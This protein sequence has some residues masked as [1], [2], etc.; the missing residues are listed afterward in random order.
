ML[1]DGYIIY[2]LQPVSVVCVSIASSALTRSIE[3]YFPQWAEL[4][5]LEIATLFLLP[6]CHKSLDITLQNQ[7]IFFT[8]VLDTLCFD[9]RILRIQSFSVGLYLVPDYA[10]CI[11]QMYLLFQ[12]S[13]HNLLHEGVG[14]V[15]VRIFW[16]LW[17]GH[18][19][20][21]WFFV[22]QG[23]KVEEET[24]D[25]LTSH[26][27]C[28]LCPLSHIY[29]NFFKM[30]LSCIIFEV[31]IENRLHRSQPHDDTAVTANYYKRKREDELVNRT[32]TKERKFMGKEYGPRTCLF[33][34]YML[35]TWSY[36]L[37]ICN[38]EVNKFHNERGRQKQNKNQSRGPAILNH[39]ATKAQYGK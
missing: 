39:T 36:F 15:L 13:S 27:S 38:H 37:N 28:Q 29:W 32:L 1:L 25:I 34:D 8:R 5:K 19:N 24:E 11:K 10:S 4:A 14:C 23:K 21:H 33:L 18:S 7:Y 26:T 12:D 6:F 16:G 2:F 31:A 30:S 3:L 22:P 20:N 17:R 9:S 35:I